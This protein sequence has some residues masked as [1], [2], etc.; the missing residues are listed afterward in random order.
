MRAGWLGLALVL[1][2]ALPARADDDGGRFTAFLGFHLNNGTLD[3]VQ[4][5]LGRTRLNES[6]ESGDYEASI[7]YLGS[8]GVVSFLSGQEGGAVLGLLGFQLRRGSTDVAQHCRQ[9][10]R[11]YAD[12]SRS[13]GGLRLG[14]SKAEF[15]ALVGAPVQWDGETARRLY[16]SEQSMSAGE[17]AQYADSPEL[18]LR[19]SFNVLVT[20]TARFVDDQL[21]EVAVWKIVSA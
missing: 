4:G 16:E 18:S 7:C 13:L 9:L 10:P 1:F 21:V 6:Y 3:D 11:H 20:V 17:R 19:G 2:V 15:S 12:A 8:N 5:R 14:M